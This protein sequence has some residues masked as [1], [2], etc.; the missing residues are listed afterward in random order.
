MSEELSKD[1]AQTLEIPFS[2]AKFGL[3]ALRIVARCQSG[4]LLGLRGGQDLRVEIDDIKLREI[5]QKDKPQYNN[6]PPSWNGTELKGLTKTV[7][8][9]LPLNKGFHTLKFIPTKGAHVESFEVRPIEDLRK[10]V[11]RL[12]DQAEDGDGRPWYTFAFLNLPLL[13]L[14]ADISVSWHFLDGDDVKLIIDNRIEKNTNSKLWKY[15]LWSARPWQVFFGA[16][17][18]SKTLTTH[19]TTDIHYIEFWV[20]KTPIF[21]TITFDLGDYLLKRIPTVENPEWTANFADDTNEMLLARLILGEAE[22]QSREAKIWVG[23]AV[24]N[25]VKAKA[26]Q[27]SIHEVILQKDQYDTF[28]SSNINFPKITDPFNEDKSQLRLKNW[29]ECYEIAQKLLSE[30]IT[31]PTIATHFHGIGVTKEWFLEHLVP[32]GKFLK[33]IDDTYFYW[34]PN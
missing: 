32:Q 5:P 11:F 31:N 17:R 9:I 6:I 20:D 27:N 29:Q 28:K 25:R 12:N 33:Q 21:H 15:W 19:L 13:S 30:E 23:G 8:F 26:W 14:T 3:Y 7:F 10:V 1:I 18:E 2:A 16:I 24:F 34:S 22:N 4:D